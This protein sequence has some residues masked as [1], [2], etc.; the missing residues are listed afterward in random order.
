MHWAK[1]LEDSYRTTGIHGYT[2]GRARADCRVDDSMV[3]S[4]SLFGTLFGF[5]VRFFL[6]FS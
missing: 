6:L 1:S 3:E 4:P 5:G 2:M